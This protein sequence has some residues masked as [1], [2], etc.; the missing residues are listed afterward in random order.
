MWIGSPSEAR[1]A[2]VRARLADPPFRFAEVRARTDL[3]D[4]NAGDPLS[5]SILSALLA[6]ALI[7]LT[8]SVGG[9]LLGATS[10]VR[11][12]SG[13]LADL[14]AQGMTP[15]MLRWQIVA[16]TGWLAAAGGAAGVAVG[17]VLAVLATVVLALTPEGTV[18]IPPLT[19]VIP[20]V[21]IVVVAL[22]V[23]G[24]VLA[25]VGVL[26]ARRFDRGTPGA[27]GVGGRRTPEA[28]RGQPEGGNG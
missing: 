16:R 12:E 13:Q 26:V 27:R 28:W 23:V 6:A 21:P 1:L 25:V 3:I 4:T 7:G 24:F 10:D 15:S 11:D 17:V 19:P 22:A 2:D 20:I 8:L 5:Q 18:P 14:E 9:L